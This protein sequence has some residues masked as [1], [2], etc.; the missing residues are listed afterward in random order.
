MFHKETGHKISG[1]FL[2]MGMGISA[3]L[4]TAK[5][6]FYCGKSGDEFCT[7]LYIAS[8]QGADV[9]VSTPKVNSRGEIALSQFEVSGRQS[10]DMTNTQVYFCG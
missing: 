2:K 6:G 1:Q 3:A 8:G 7:S 4:Q 10:C 5:A 9:G